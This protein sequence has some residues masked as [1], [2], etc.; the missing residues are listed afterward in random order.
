Y[1]DDRVD[2]YQ[3]IYSYVEDFDL[4]GSFFWNLG[5][6][7]MWEDAWYPCE[8]VGGWWADTGWSDATAIGTDTNHVLQGERSLKLSYEPTNGHGHAAFCLITNEQWVVRLVGGQATG[9]NRVKYYWNVYNPGTPVNVA[10]ALRVYDTWGD[11]HESQ[12]QTVT[13]GWNRVRFD[14]SAGTWK[15]AST[16]WE[17]TGFVREVL[18]DVRQVVF[19]VYGDNGADELYLDDITIRRDDGFII[20]AEDPVCDVIRDHADVMREKRGG[21]TIHLA[22]AAGEDYFPQTTAEQ[23]NYTAA[24]STWMVE[25]YLHGES[26]TQSQAQIYGET[27]HDPAHNDEI[28]PWSC[29][30]WCYNHAPAGYY[31]SGRWRPTLLDALRE[32][33]Y[34]VDYVPAGGRR[35]PTLVVCGTNW[36]YKTVRGF[37]ASRKPYDGGYYP[38]TNNVFALYGFWINDP[39]AE[40]LGHNLYAT[41]DEM[42]NIFLASTTNSQFWIVAEPPQDPS[43]LALAEAAIDGTVMEIVPSEPNPGV[44]ALLG[45][46]PT[47]MREM[48]EGEGSLL[49]SIPLALRSDPGFMAAFNAAPVV[50]YYTV[51]TNQPDQYSLAVGGVQ[52]PATTRF[53]LKL[54]PDGSLRQAAWCDEPVAYEPVPFHTAEW[55]AR[56]ALGEGGATAVLEESE[57]LCPTGESAFHPHWDMIFDVAGTETFCRVGLGVD[58]SGDADED[59]MTDGEELY[60]GSDPDSALSVFAIEGGSVSVIGDE[61]TVRWPSVSGRTYTLYRCTD[62]M[63]GFSA[64]AQNLEATAP[65]NSYVD[66]VSA[67]TVYYRVQA[68]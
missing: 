3:E 61:L 53:V 16:G 22:T 35:V 48:D 59:G 65:E 44:A 8:E 51:N 46:G 12:A 10:I 2:V 9:V 36:S 31:F 6:Q 43:L 34:W 29:A 57:F 41:A 21:Y 5:Y 68:E 15:S 56:Q 60:S 40:G 33:V 24:A 18:E 14:L 32:V 20:F 39:T 42:T 66:H 4:D 1:E 47:G 37:Q 64:I 17:H 26:F 11:W 23:S 7:G 28:T 54:A 55:A 13:T 58:L 25:R 49:D 27:T 30:Q 19:L 67:P 62:L 63:Q 38:A 45:G 52:G 50:R